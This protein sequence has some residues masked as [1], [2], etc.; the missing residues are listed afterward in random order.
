MS[1]GLKEIYCRTCGELIKRF[2]RSAYPRRHV[3]KELILKAIRRHYKERH[4]K[5]FKEFSKKA[6]RTKIERGILD[7]YASDSVPT[8]KARRKLIKTPKVKGF[9][10]FKGSGL[11]RV[12]ERPR[13]L[14]PEFALYMSQGGSMVQGSLIDAGLKEEEHGK[15][16]LRTDR[17]SIF[18]YV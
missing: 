17:F 15:W 10:D 18:V 7:P 8:I 13:D 11:I 4:P 9:K 14:F 12:L 1:K 6:V 3:P 5:R 2:R 16:V